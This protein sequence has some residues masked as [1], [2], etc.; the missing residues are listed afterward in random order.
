MIIGLNKNDILYVVAHGGKFNISRWNRNELFYDLHHI[1]KTTLFHYTHIASVQAMAG[2]SE[3]ICTIVPSPERDVW[4]GNG[5]RKQTSF[6]S[7]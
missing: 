2:R 7:D 4:T 1:C 6:S 5:P 3:C